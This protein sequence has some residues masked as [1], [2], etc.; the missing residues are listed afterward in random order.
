MNEEVISKYVKEDRFFLAN[1]YDPDLRTIIVPLPSLTEWYGQF[2][3]HEPTWEEAIKYVDGYGLEPKDQVFKYVQMPEKVKKIADVIRIKTKQKK[4]AAITSDDIY[5]ELEDNRTAYKNE[6]Q[7]IQ[8]DIKRRYHG[9]WFFNNGKP[10]YI[11]AWHYVYLNHWDITNNDRPIDGLPNYRDSDRRMILFKRYAYT[12]TKVWYPLKVSYRKTGEYKE[13]YFYNLG[14]AHNF[15]KEKIGAL[16][17]GMVEGHEGFLVD[18]GKRVDY[19]VATP[20][21]RRRGATSQDACIQYLIVTEQK[22]RYGGIQSFNEGAAFNDVFSDK[23]IRPWK[24]IPFYLKPTHEGTS[25]PKSELKFSYPAERTQLLANAKTDAHEGW[26]MPRSATE[27]AFDGTKLYCVLRDEGGK[28]DGYPY[29]LGEWWSVHKKCIAQAGDIHGFALIP[30]TVG[31]MDSGGGKEYAKFLM[32]SKWEERD[33][34]GHTRTGCV[35][36]FEPAYDGLDGYI[37]KYGMSIIED[38]I[39][40]V[41]TQGG[42][43][44]DVGAKTHLMRARTNYEIAGDQAG[45]IGE[46]RD[47]PFTLREALTKSAKDS[48][49]DLKVIR[50]RIGELKYGRKDITFRADLEWYSDFGGEVM[51]I[52]DPDGKYIFSREPVTAGKNSKLWVNDETFDKGGYYMPDPMYA[53]KYIVGADAFAF[54]EEDVLGRRKSNG[55]IAV[56][57]LRDEVIDPPEKAVNE[58]VTNKYTVTYSQRVED[59]NEYVEDVLKLCILHGCYVYPEMNVPIVSDKFKE[60]GYDGYLLH[61]VDEFGVKKPMCGRKTTPS[62]KEEIFADHMTYIRHYGSYENHSD[63]LEEFANIGSPEEMT[64]YDLFTAAGYCLL[65]AKSRY[66]KLMQMVH[67][68]I[69]LDSNPFETFNY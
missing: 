64:Y 68:E 25:A 22:K 29:D 26:I 33:G 27:R 12:N 37:D 3:G 45:L 24:K 61:D 44:V 9:Y 32:G 13:E 67:E 5:K 66:P 36:Y 46:M 42:K 11:D 23:L 28:I 49:F 43:Y 8:R 58:W 57:Y 1:E 14:A 19:G 63:L 38:P 34:N 62:T 18:K 35:T 53:N 7:F 6:I 15:A 52:P 54:N 69:S 41:E 59:K 21:R 4:G 50:K 16:V 40:P 60:W 56:F 17:E 31:E 51:I 65:G 30:S 55:G 39:L 47:F 20:K 10:T 2:L 48:G